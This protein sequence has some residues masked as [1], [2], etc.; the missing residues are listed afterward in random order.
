LSMLDVC[1]AVHPSVIDA[2]HVRNESFEDIQHDAVLCEQKRFVAL[3]LP[4]LEELFHH[5][6]FARLA[7]VTVVISNLLRQGLVLNE[8]RVIANFA[9]DIYS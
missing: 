2:G 7:P 8:I 6:H 5:L 4:D 1:G 3:V 9:K